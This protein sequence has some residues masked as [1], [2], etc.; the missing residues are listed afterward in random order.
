MWHIIGSTSQLAKLFIETIPPR[1]P[2]E[3]YC[4]DGSGDHIIDMTD[5]DSFKNLIISDGDRVIIFAAISSPDICTN[6]YD[7][8]YAVNVRGTSELI[9]YSLER[10]ARILFY[11]S[12]T[13]IGN[14]KKEPVDEHYKPQPVGI[15]ATM[16]RMIEKEFEN[17]PHFKTIRLSY[18][19]TGKDNYSSYL[20]SCVSN[21]K[22]AEVFDSFYRNV[23][24]YKDVMDASVAVLLNYD[25][26]QT[27]IIHLSGPELLSR[28]DIAACYKEVI[29]NELSIKTVEPPVDFFVS[30]PPVISTTSLYLEGVLGRKP[31][32]LKDAMSDILKSGL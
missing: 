2:F 31:T 18:V 27:S 1:Q 23:V 28:L 24:Y 29:N 5:P 21:K 20:N 13:V 7:E 12:D 8:A 10:G 19:Y 16:K 4:R 6:H 32:E 14:T 17:E 26:I 22:T 25:D 15:Y 11:S 3:T 9:R 30:R